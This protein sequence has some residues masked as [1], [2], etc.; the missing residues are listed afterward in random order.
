M[1]SQLSEISKVFVQI[2]VEVPWADVEKAMEGSYSE[3]GRTAKVRGFRP[4]KVPRNVLKQLFGAR[5]RQEV[6]NNLVES[7]L[8]KAV[9]QHQLAVVAVPPLESTPQ[10]KPGEPLTFTAKLEVR[11]KIEQVDIDGIA[12]TR[13]TPKVEEAQVDAALEQLRNQHAEVVVVDPP[14]PAIE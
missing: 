12:L 14:R 1:Q 13:S 3:L 5:V 4:G 10:L 8:G 6:L 9:E 7:G 2:S 11:P